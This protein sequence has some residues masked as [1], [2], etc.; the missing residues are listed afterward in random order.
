MNNT[1]KKRKRYTSYKR[2]FHY[3]SFRCIF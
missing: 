3:L 1:T 2:T